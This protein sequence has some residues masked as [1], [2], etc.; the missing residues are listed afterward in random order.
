MVFVAYLIAIVIASYFMTFMT[1]F[2]I[3]REQRDKRFTIVFT[4]STAICVCLGGIIAV[5]Q[6]VI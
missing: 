5:I 6:N 2:F 1:M 4:I 3:D